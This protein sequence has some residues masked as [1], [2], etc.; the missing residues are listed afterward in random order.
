MSI[1]FTLRVWRFCKNP[2]GSKFG[3]QLLSLSF[4]LFFITSFRP[5][6]LLYYGEIFEDSDQKAYSVFS[7]IEPGFLYNNVGVNTAGLREVLVEDDQGNLTRSIQPHKREETIR[8]VVKSGDSITK[9]AHKFGL[10]V[11]TLLWANNLTVKESVH[12]GQ[13]MKVPPTDGV[14]YKIQLG[15]TLNEIAT[16]HNTEAE[17]ILA[18]NDTQNTAR[19]ELNKEIFIPGAQKKFI[20]QK[21]IVTPNNSGY[22]NVESLGFTIRRPS[23]GVLT[24][25]FHRGHYALDIANKLKTPIYAVADG[26]VIQ[27]DEGWN[28]GFGNYVIID[29][30]GGVETLYAHNSKL[31]V[32]AGDRVKTGELIALMGNTG[33]VWGPT[34]IHLHFELHIRGRKVNP[35][36]YF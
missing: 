9:I 15:D 33:N 11:S 5:P 21:T 10:K 19:L 18:F 3:F 14:F 2:L 28:Y 20:P 8:Y 17:K 35:A 31:M 24:Q 36:N 6:Q 34:G 29:H 1:G 22:G 25:G 23:K 32:R 12:V 30:G 16:A 7:Y 26:L 13:K 4:L 27:A